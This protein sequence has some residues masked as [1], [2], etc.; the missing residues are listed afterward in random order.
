M[1][2]QVIVQGKTVRKSKN[3]L[4][5]HRGPGFRYKCA[6]KGQRHRMSFEYHWETTRP[7]IS[8]ADWPAYLS[9]R[10][11][12]ME[13]MGA[14][15]QTQ[16]PALN[17]RWFWIALWLAISICSKVALHNGSP[18][19]VGNPNRIDTEIARATEAYEKSDYIL[20]AELA[21][22]LSLKDQRAAF[23]YGM[24]LLHRKM[25]QEALEFSRAAVQQIPTPQ[26]LHLHATAA[27]VTQNIVEAEEAFKAW[28]Q[29]AAHTA[30][31]LANWGWFLHSTGRSHEAL[32]VLEHAVQE[33]PQDPFCWLNYSIVLAALDQPHATEARAKADALMNPQTRG[34]LLQTP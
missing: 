12:A 19:Q 23:F 33:F 11:K 9:A 13:H 30:P 31:Y 2:H 24:S 20:A 32:K 4:H 8:V 7:E 3:E 1:R 17:R 27:A 10:N 18:H 5:K 29:I 15:V 16:R 25:N 6:V 21:Q 34:K 14:N 28:G 22:P 26:V